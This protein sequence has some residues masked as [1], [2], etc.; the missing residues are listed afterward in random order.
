MLLRPN[1]VETVVFGCQYTGHEIMQGGDLILKNCSVSLPTDAASQFLYK[2]TFHSKG[3]N[4]VSSPVKEVAVSLNI[5]LLYSVKCI[6]ASLRNALRL[7]LS[8]YTKCRL[9]I[10][11]LTNKILGKMCSMTE[12]KG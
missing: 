6:L 1:K 5:V 12:S 8:F 4:A 9:F 10:G 3:R 7:F 2:L 11:V